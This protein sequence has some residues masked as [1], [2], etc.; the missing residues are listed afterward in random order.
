MN[1]NT[2]FGRGLGATSEWKLPAME[3][4]KSKQA[5]G[6]SPYAFVSWL[7]GVMDSA[8]AG[9]EAFDFLD[10][11]CP[12]ESCEDDTTLSSEQVALIRRELAKVVL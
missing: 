11:I 9:N 2:G 12:C 4:A 6:M 1:E 5:I 8:D 7:R 10:I 3:I